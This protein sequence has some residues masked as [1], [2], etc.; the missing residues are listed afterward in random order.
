MK[1]L[2]VAFSGAHST[3]KTTAAQSLMKLLEKEGYRGSLVTETAR[4]C[5]FPVNREA[6]SEAQKW[7]WDRQIMTEANAMRT[8][9]KW[10]A[11]FMIFDRTSMDSLCYSQWHRE[12]AAGGPLPDLVVGGLELPENA[13]G[14]VGDKANEFVKEHVLSYDLVWLTRP[15]RRPLKDDGFR[16]TDKEW[17]TEIAEIFSQSWDAVQ[18]HRVHMGKPPLPVKPFR[19][20][21]KCAEDVKA[22]LRAGKETG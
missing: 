6:T 5:P 8:G 7:I 14:W 11:D 20:A 2:K 10:G 12:K 17:Q 13:W 16:D 1:P 3:G 22:L 15:D 19:G 18:K 21:G 4:S 9:E